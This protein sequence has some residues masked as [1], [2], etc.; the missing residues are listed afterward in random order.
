MG[1]LRAAGARQLGPALAADPACDPVLARRRR[2]RNQGWGGVGW[3]AHLVVRVVLK[4]DVATKTSQL[5]RRT[6]EG[7]MPHAKTKTMPPGCS[8]RLS[9]LI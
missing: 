7:L 8:T 3:S 9:T 4:T 6:Y 1:A 5:P 2:M